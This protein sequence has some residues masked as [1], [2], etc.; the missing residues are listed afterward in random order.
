LR[1]PVY[2]L[3]EDLVFPPVDHAED[4]LVAVGGDLRPERLLLAYT[5][6]IFPWYS[7]DQPILWHSPDPRFVLTRERFRVPRR[8]R[9]LMKTRPFGLTMDRAFSSVIRQCA[10]VPRPGQPGTWITDEM[11]AAYEG[12]HDLG[13]AHSVEAWK[14]NELVG[15]LYGV[16][17]GAAFF[18]ESMF[19]QEAD[20]SKV[21][22]AALVERLRAWKIEL[23]DCQI[24][25][26]HLRRF[27]AE[28]MPRAEYVE[29]L[30]EALTHPNRRGKWSFTSE[31]AVRDTRGK[32]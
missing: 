12:L 25:T 14:R 10:S 24:E 30:R 31:E 8:L 6:G 7:E 11:I 20:A 19:S 1:V 22:F 28:N 13:F 18:G 9:R 29:L 21:A 15:G 2:W 17:L 32:R 3:P 16:S 26:E 27:G 4:G 5:L 23:I